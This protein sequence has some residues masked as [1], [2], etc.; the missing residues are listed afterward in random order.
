MPVPEMVTARGPTTIELAVVLPPTS[1]VAPL[2]T[3][4]GM[5]LVAN[6]KAT[7]LPPAVAFADIV[8]VL[9]GASIAVIIAPAGM[10][11]PDP[12]PPT[13]K[14]DVLGRSIVFAPADGVALMT[15]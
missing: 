8:I 13:T 14:P 15:T 1:R 4:M 3:V 12:P 7:G 5:V 9:L 6:V 2:T 11:V 10:P